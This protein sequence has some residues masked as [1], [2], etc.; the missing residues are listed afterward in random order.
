MTVLATVSQET[1]DLALASMV[2][3]DSPASS[4][5]AVLFTAAAMRGK[6]KSEFET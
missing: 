1:R 4:M 6:V 5:A 2:R 3:D